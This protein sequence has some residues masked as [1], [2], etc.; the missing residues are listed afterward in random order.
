MKGLY[1]KLISH[2]DELSKDLPEC[3]LE[4]DSSRYK[5]FCHGILNRFELGFRKRRSNRRKFALC[6]SK[7]SSLLCNGRIE[8]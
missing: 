1:Y 3:F 6:N 8:K 4:N 7:E 5:Y 2:L